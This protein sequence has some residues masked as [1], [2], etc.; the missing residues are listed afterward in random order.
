MAAT[1]HIARKGR[2]IGRHAE[3]ELPALVSLGQVQRTDHWWRAGM[4]EWL[5]VGSTFDPPATRRPRPEDHLRYTCERCGSRFDQPKVEQDGNVLTEL[6]YWLISPVAGGFYTAGRALSATK[7]CP[8]CG[9][10]H[11]VDDPW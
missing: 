5:P 3:H 7:R 2:I 4:R 6:F 10:E 9:S 11:L 1:I 8:N